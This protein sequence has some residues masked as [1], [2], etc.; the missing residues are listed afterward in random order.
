LQNGEE[1]IRRLAVAV[2]VEA[3]VRQKMKLREDLS[4][5]RERYQE[6]IARVHTMKV[7]ER[8]SF[9][10]TIQAEL[11]KV[12]S[13]ILTAEQR[14]RLQQIHLQTHGP[15]AFLEDQVQRALRLGQEQKRKIEEIVKSCTQREKDIA[16]SEAGRHEKRA[17]VQ[18][19]QRQAMTALQALLTPQQQQHWKDLI[20]EPFE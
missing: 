1:P 10:K 9:R 16:D 15:G 13:R 18:Q 7:Q 20:G 3:D 14:K 4:R 11:G 8:E 17:Q 12:A 5:V 2:Q 6:E 19:Q